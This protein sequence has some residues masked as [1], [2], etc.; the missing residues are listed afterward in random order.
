MTFPAP[1]VFLQPFH[2]NPAVFMWTEERP[3]HQREEKPAICVAISGGFH[4]PT[5]LRWVWIH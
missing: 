3:A 1:V 4:K 5:G 2:G